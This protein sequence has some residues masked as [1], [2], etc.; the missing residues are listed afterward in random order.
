MPEPR[1]GEIW[2][3]NLDAG[4]GHE[5]LARRP[6]LI[7]SD[8]QFNSGRAGLVIIIPL[9]SQRM[10]IPYHVVVAPP[11]GGLRVERYV[12]CEDIRSISKE[13]LLACWGV[14]TQATLGDVEHRLRMLLRL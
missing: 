3:G 10:G 11:E 13:R 12:K 4:A 2:L 8:D 7:V 1:R 14:V 6:I 9:T 5:Q